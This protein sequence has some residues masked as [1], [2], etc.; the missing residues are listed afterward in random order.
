MDGRGIK[1]SISSIN[2][3][4]LVQFKSSHYHLDLIY[5]EG[6]GGK[7]SSHS[8]EFY[9]SSDRSGR[10]LKSKQNWIELIR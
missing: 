10:K 4:E 8:E 5:S 1:E 6:W 7:E 2:P 3:D 9:Y